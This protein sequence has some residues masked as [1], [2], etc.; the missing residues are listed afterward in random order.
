MA[1]GGN[2]YINGTAFD[3]VNAFAPSYVVDIVSGA[4]GS[5]AFS[6]PETT[7]ITVIPFIQTPTSDYNP[8]ININGNVVSWSGLSSG[9][10]IVYGA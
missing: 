3:V 6:L 8:V 4:S 10:L 7:N 9:A 2:T 1:Y 5:I